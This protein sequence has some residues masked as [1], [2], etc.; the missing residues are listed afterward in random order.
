MEPRSASLLTGIKLGMAGLK[1]PTSKLDGKAKA[2]KGGKRTKK[3]T[4]RPKGITS[5]LQEKTKQDGRD[6][7][8]FPPPEG[9]GGII[10]EL[11]TD[12]FM[13]QK[14]RVA[15][16]DARKEAKDI[17]T[18]GFELIE[19]PEIMA[20]FSY[21]DFLEGKH[22]DAYHERLCAFVKAKLGAKT[23]I[24]YSHKL[25]LSPEVD[26]AAGKSG[27]ARMIH[28]DY[29]IPNALNNVQEAL[30]GKGLPPWDP[31]AKGARCQ[32]M[33]VW[34]NISETPIMN[35]SL[36]TCDATSVAADD[37]GGIAAPTLQSTAHHR[38]C[39]FSRM[40]RHEALLFMHW[41]SAWARHRPTFHSAFVDPTAPADAPHRESIESRLLIVY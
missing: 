11:F 34:R 37:I 30:E 28:A 20:E 9:F 3:A 23:V 39:Y 15:M 21:G 27:Y 5:P 24:C 17:L 14:V 7:T 36:A 22:V 38:W 16:H 35:N 41:D 40:E 2:K 31:K 4:W 19:H 29:S 12:P 32:I 18:H 10:V 1:K 26:Y 13:Q 6:V 33:N 25:R 8:V